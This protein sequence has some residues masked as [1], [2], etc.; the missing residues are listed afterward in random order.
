MAK[1]YLWIKAVGYGME[2]R[3][4]IFGGTRERGRL[5]CS[6][7]GAMAGRRF[8]R[9]SPRFDKTKAWKTRGAQGD[10]T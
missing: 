9:F 10:L 2:G 4:L 3:D 7:G 8:W 1:G 6:G 5:Q